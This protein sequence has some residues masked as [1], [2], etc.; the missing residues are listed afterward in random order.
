MAADSEDLEISDCICCIWRG[1][2]VGYVS[3]TSRLWAFLTAYM[4]VGVLM[5]RIRVCWG[6]PLFMETTI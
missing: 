3:S 4:R 6:V 2:G 1:V 5:M